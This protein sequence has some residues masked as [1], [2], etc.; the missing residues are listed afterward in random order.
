MPAV[1]GGQL[2]GAVADHRH[3]VGLQ[4]FQGQPQIQDRLGAGADHRHRGVGQLLQVRGDIHGGFRS[5]VHSA[6]AAGGEE[7]DARH[8]GDHHGGGHGGGAVL[9]P[10][11]DRRQ[12]PA[13]HL[14]DLPA[15]FAEVFNLLRGQ[16]RLQPPADDG[17]GGRHGAV[18]PDDALH[19]ERRFHVPGIGHAVGDNG[20]FQRH[21]RLAGRQRFRNFLT[22]IQIGILHG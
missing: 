7:L 5:P 22:Q 2:L 3:A 4:V 20:G 11:A 14:R 21:H 19:A 13:A 1:E 9:A 12:I 17:D 10:G 8:M 15:L 16:P 18:F 6:D